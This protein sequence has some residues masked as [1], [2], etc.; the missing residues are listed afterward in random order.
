MW[1]C[2]VGSYERQVAQAEVMHILAGERLFT[3]TGGTP[4][5]VKT[6]GTLFFP[7]NTTGIWEI[8]EPLREVYV[9]LQ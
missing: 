2:T 7:T 1:E 5:R 3:P 4:F 8:L 9:I 6:G